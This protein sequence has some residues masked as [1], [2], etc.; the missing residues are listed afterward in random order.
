M[1]RPKYSINWP[2]AAFISLILGAMTSAC[3]EDGF[4]TSP[5]DQISFS[6]DTLDM[7]EVFTG[8]LAATHRFIVYNRNTKGL[9]I[10]RIALSGENA[11][12]FRL[13]VDGFA[14][15]EFSDVEIRAKDSIFVYVDVNLPENGTA[16]PRRIK[17]DIDFSVN[18]VTSSMPL[19]VTG[20]DITRVKG[21]VV[22][23]DETFTP[24][25]P[26][27][28]IDSLVI[29]QGATLTLEPGTRLLFHDGA[30]L[31]VRGSLRSAG[32]SE[33]PVILTG[34]RTGEVISG[35]SFDIMSRQ[36]FGVIFHESSESNVLE[37]TEVSN[38]QVGVCAYGDHE[39]SHDFNTPQLQIV[40]CRLRNSGD[41]VLRAVN[42][43][44]NAFGC[45][46]AE[47][48]VDLVLLAGGSYRFDQCTASNNYLF[49]AISGSAW[50]FIPPQDAIADN[51][52]VISTSALITNSITHGYGG[53]AD[54]TDL[55][56]DFPDV[57]FQNCMFK[58]N[59]SDDNNFN[60]CHW[61]SDPLF[62]TVRNDYL[63]DYRVKPES[64]AIG[65]ADLNIGTAL[66]PVDF[67]GC[68]RTSDLGAYVFVQP[69]E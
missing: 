34:D 33:N 55:S 65:A 47:A 23:A 42:S 51:P 57:L 35:V 24:G 44:I 14:G 61:D 40:N 43:S 3:I 41:V 39:S 13:N 31:D 6:A 4:S 7:G 68:T 45:E 18:G 56:K 28:I 46:F 21:H 59:G 53:D 50:H 2:L 11:G 16:D 26:Y 10:S 22:T 66:S 25:R 49:S 52:A 69:A 8:E 37:F 58:A 29:E 62:Y 63:F 17:A 15:S 54:P 27:R 20:R 67:Y 64:P 30:R 19:A 32:T 48:A 38:T 1:T 60:S 5:S 9:S 12:Y 36:W